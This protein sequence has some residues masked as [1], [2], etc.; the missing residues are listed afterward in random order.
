MLEGG[1]DCLRH[2][3]SFPRTTLGAPNGFRHD[4]CSVALP[5]RGVRSA[6]L[7]QLRDAVVGL[8]LVGETLRLEVEQLVDEL[9]TRG[10]EPGVGPLD[11]LAHDGADVGLEI[12]DD[13]ETRLLPDA[14]DDQLDALDAISDGVDEA[15]VLGVGL[16][17]APEEASLGEGPLR[18]VDDTGMVLLQGG[19]VHVVPFVGLS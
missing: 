6:Q 15:L 5:V 16:G 8:P 4:T 1:G 17:V 3:L 13:L 7:S 14:R 10:G 19:N 12:D 9:L 11:E 18:S 2:F